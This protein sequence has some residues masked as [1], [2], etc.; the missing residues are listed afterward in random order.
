M[1][2]PDNNTETGRQRVIDKI[3]ARFR[4]VGRE[5]TA[6]PAAAH[7]PSKQ[8]RAHKIIKTSLNM[9]AVLGWGGL[10]LTVMSDKLA[11]PVDNMVALGSRALT[12][13]EADLARALFGN[14]FE[15]DSIRLRFHNEAP[16]HM[17]NRLNNPRGVLAY[18]NGTDTENIHFVER[19]YHAHDYSRADDLATRGGVFM[20][21][22]THIWQNRTG[23]E[24][25]HC[26]NYSFTLTDQSR[27][28]DF[29]NEQQAEIIRSYVT[30]FIIP[31][32][33][34]MEVT[35]RANGM[36]HAM[37]GRIEDHLSG[38]DKNLARVIEAA[39]PHAAASRLRIQTNFNNAAICAVNRARATPRIDYQTHFNNC[40]DIHVRNISGQTL[41]VDAQRDV[42]PSPHAHLP[43][44]RLLDKSFAPTPDPDQLAAKTASARPPRPGV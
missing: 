9:I 20:H 35:A 16:D 14:D 25:A 1:D 18:V 33:P 21:E 40:A 32:H 7:P 17:F 34:T 2:Q 19:L 13:G 27:F 44:A 5:R 38:H 26:E 22:L 43:D 10:G 23:N 15:T 11:V 24:A 39:F 37:G 12:S 42:T 6:P 36:I 31:G 41:T 30:R 29:C 4:K 8:Q 3:A 28:E